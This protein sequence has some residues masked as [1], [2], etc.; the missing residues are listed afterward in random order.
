MLIG[1]QI[2]TPSRVLVRQECFDDIGVFDESLPTKQDWDFYIRLCQEWNIAA[3]EDHLCF[4]TIHDSMS[5]SPESALQDNKLILDKHENLIQRRGYW[6]QSQA[7][8]EERVGRAYMRQRKIRRAR[9]H[10]AKSLWKDST[11]GRIL[12]YMLTFTHPGIVERMRT[13]KRKI[14]IEKNGCGDFGQIDDF[15]MEETPR[16]DYEIN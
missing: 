2:G 12:L 6:Q 1:N 5:S 14:S 9:K 13:L 7:E 3:V 15:I 8:I 4:R 16:G 11:I 10:F